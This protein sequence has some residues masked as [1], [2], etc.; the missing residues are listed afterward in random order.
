MFGS[1]AQMQR[2][3]DTNIVLLPY[4]QKFVFLLAQRLL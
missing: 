3:F 4:F 2:I 1:L